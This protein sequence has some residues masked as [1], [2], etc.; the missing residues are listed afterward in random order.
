MKICLDAGHYGKYNRSPVVGEYYESNFTWRF[1]LMLKKALEA[2][3]IEVI[4]TRTVQSAD[5]GLYTRGQ[6][7]K[8]CDLFISV[9]SNACNSEAV[10]YPLACCCI[11]GKADSLGLKLAKAVAAQMG[12]RQA[13]RI[14][15][16]RGEDG[17]Y[18]G[19]LRGAAAVG[20]PGILL[21]HSFHTNTAA[22]KWLLN[23]ANLEKLAQAEAKVIADHYKIKKPVVTTAKTDQEKFIDTM[24]AKGKKICAENKLLL[25]LCIAQACLESA[26]GTSELAVQANN[27]FGIKKGNGWTGNLYYKATKEWTNGEYITITAPFRAYPTMTDCIK[28]YAAKLTG[29]TR[30]AN[31]VGCTDINK[32]CQY[33][34]E[35]G[36]ATSPTYTENLLKVVEKYNLTWYDNANEQ[37][38]GGS[39]LYRVQCGAYKSK[40]NAEAQRAKL[41]AA[42]FET[43][44]VQV[45]RLYKIQCGAFSRKANADAM[46][47]KLKKAGFAAFVTTKKA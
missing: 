38:S 14:T 31:L 44:I 19:V 28:D 34:R 42:G 18:Y 30:Y 36:W 47:A 10:D 26:Y 9:H 20:V 4:K 29:M 22:T 46:L 6:K 40:A 45:N 21:E 24:V 13:G 39:V 16:R 17:D 25:S 3:G 11:N 12:T 5:M 37:D 33:I 8:G 32:A 35:D 27:L 7:A 43:V 41:K 1:H 15:K 23:D 2:Y